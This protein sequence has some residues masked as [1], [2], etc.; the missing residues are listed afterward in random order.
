MARW[1]RNLRNLALA[2]VLAVG[3]G[4][5]WGIVTG[6]ALEIVSQTLRRHS[7]YEAIEVLRDGTA[8]VE[9]VLTAYGAPVRYRTLDGKAAAAPPE[10]NRASQI[11]LPGPRAAAVTFGNEWRIG[12]VGTDSG[13]SA[14]W[15]FVHDGQRHGHGY[16]VGYDPTTKLP[17]GYIGRGG[18]RLSPPPEAEQFPV[19]GDGTTGRP[20]AI[21]HG[22]TVQEAGAGVAG[23]AKAVRSWNTLLLADDGLL[24]ID[25][26]QQ[27]AC[28]LFKLPNTVSGAKQDVR[29]YDGRQIKPPRLLLRDPQRIYILGPTGQAIQS[30]PIPDDLRRA[31][32]SYYPLE[33]S[34]AVIVCHSAYTNEGWPIDL[35]WL[36]AQGQVTE[37]RT[38][39][40]WPYSW[41][42][43]NI[44]PYFPAVTM[45][46]PAL[47][48]AGVCIIEPLKWMEESETLGYRAALA[49]AWA[50]DW[51]QV[52]LICFVSAVLAVL[53]Y[54][55]HRRY[56]LEWPGVWTTLVFL[57]GVPFYLAYLAHHTWPVRLPCPACGE[58]AP[59]DR[60]TCL[61][62]GEPF[63][64][65]APKGIEV[66]A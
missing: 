59:R 39:M 60:E 57:F 62:C 28:M 4:I 19:Q 1:S 45:P 23:H 21:F 33:D 49:E 34:R 5:A 15:F 3:A 17:V 10:K 42:R 18:S 41:F 44:V 31:G 56:G 66:F 24:G 20:G 47:Y 63:A 58:P 11:Y 12:H 38:V 7:D 54:R 30:F 6:F 13:Q 50:E 14:F 40:I 16:F 65:P 53:V 36:D 55:R 61:A 2:L 43:R 52:L 64:P 9:R 48:T 25:L 37:R 32:F 51:P 29:Y 26:R 22:H 8:L 35:Y 46:C 27:T